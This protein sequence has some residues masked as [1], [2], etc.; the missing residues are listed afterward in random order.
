MSCIFGF[1]N[2]NGKPISPDSWEE[3]K[4][5]TG[6][7]SPD[8]SSEYVAGNIALGYQGLLLNSSETIA[9]DNFTYTEQG[10]TIVADTRLDNRAELIKLLSI[11]DSTIPDAVLILKSFI[12]YQKKCVDHLIGAFAFA[13][14]DHSKEELFCVRD[15]IGIKPFNYY[16][17]DSK[18]LF[19]S[20]RKSIL[21]VDNIDKHAD[22]EFIILKICRKMAIEDKTENIHIKK[23]LPA[24]CL[25][26]NKNNIKI[27][28]YWNF[29]IGKETYY[30]NDQD[31]ID[32]F[33]ELF[34]QSINARLVGSSVISAHLSGGLDSSGIASVAHELT[35]QRAKTFHSFSYTFPNKE[36]IKIPRNLYNFNNLV[37]KQVEFSGIQNNHNVIKSRFPGFKK[38]I[39]LETMVC[40]G[41]AWSNNVR[42]EYEI[43]C[44]MQENKVGINLSGFLGDEI[45]T[46]FVR[47][48]YL[49]YLNKGKY[50]KF[51]ASKHKGKRQPLK[52]L[53]LFGLHLAGKFNL[54]VGRKS[55]ARYYQGYREKQFSDKYI[56]NAHLFA[57]D[58][59]DKNS[60]LRKA[61]IT[62]SGPEIHNMIPL[63]LKEYQ[64]NHINRFWTSRR[65]E[66]EVL[67][68]LNHRIEY[69]YPMADIRLLQYVL[70][71]PVEQKRNNNHSRLLYRKAMKGYVHDEIRM[72]IKHETIL[73]PLNYYTKLLKSTHIDFWNTIFEETPLDFLDKKQIDEMNKYNRE[74]DKFYHYAILAEMVK[75]KKLT[76]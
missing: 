5:K 43:Q 8:N 2:L 40:D 67:S 45:I 42:T 60:D 58:Y 59:L 13:I 27:T 24:H 18:F 3:I 73:K 51:F 19:G 38:H 36:N 30:K 41:I 16:F 17:K 64:R 6:W 33:L 32:H 35:N 71:V 20:Q 65:I 31:Y 23:L 22:W 14:W 7:W 68:A 70:S 61:L 53:G 69:R 72:G 49:E 21:T 44:E 29:D 15:H 55:L 62:K 1:W 34:K 12:K 56:T 52:F 39:E 57:P 75:T 50:L 47:P 11:S 74:L 28:R 25:T 4:S 48:Y 46:S 9:Q 37:K 54:K 66:S 26:I 10:L 76:Y 63:S